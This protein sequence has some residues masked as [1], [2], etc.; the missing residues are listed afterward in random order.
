MQ[1]PT[2][3]VYVTKERMRPPTWPLF[4]VHRRDWPGMLRNGWAEAPSKQEASS[5]GL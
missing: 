3:E 2:F 5:A 4:G 1:V